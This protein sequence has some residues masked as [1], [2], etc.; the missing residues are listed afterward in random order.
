[1][2]RNK[3]LI[4]TSKDDAHAD[5]IIFR[6]N[7]MGYGDRIIRLNTEDFLTNVLV[8]FDGSSFQLH[9]R[10]SGRF[11]ISDEVYSVW[12]RRPK[13]FQLDHE[14]DPAVADFLK[15]QGTACLRGLY[16][17]THD[18]VLWVNPLSALHRA[19]IKLQQLQ[20]AQRVGLAIPQT[21][22][23]N[24]PEQA[25]AFYDQVGMVCT[26][27]LDE[28]N[29]TLDG[30]LY[31]MF[32]R[33]L[34]QR[35]DLSDHLDSIARC[36]VLFQEY[37]E[38]QYD[39]RVIVIGEQIVSFAIHSQ[40]DQRSIHDFRRIAPELQKHEIHELPVDVLQGIRT[41]MQSQGLVYSAIDLVR[42]QDGNYVFLENNA[43]GQWL[44]LENI[45]GFRLSDMMIAL[46]LGI[47]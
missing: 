19:R 21:L 27:S 39:I 1:M 36:P 17:C 35:S 10:D 11:L 29:F 46:L 41:F 26:K 5:Y 6:C 34:H 18:D 47:R 45:T 33:V 24:D 12:Y 37:I 13:D 8:H 25:L 9:I 4:V 2:L 43:N 20:M 3:L 32:T 42:S 28:P 38:K 31:P 15:L 23:T 22:V 16:F 44:W 30:H 7:E 40:E 14:A